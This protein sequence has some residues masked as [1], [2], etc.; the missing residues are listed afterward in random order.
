[1]VMKTHKK[2][3][4]LG[5]ALGY[6][7]GEL[8]DVRFRKYGLGTQCC[9]ANW[10]YSSE[11]GKAMIEKATLKAT[12]PRVELEKATNTSK[13]RKRLPVVLKQT[14]IVFNEFIRLRDKHQP[15]ISSGFPLGSLY[16]A[17][18][19]FSVKQYSGLRFDDRNVHAQ[20]IGDNR[21]KEGNF[22]DYLVQVYLRLDAETV[23]QLRKDAHYFKIHPKKWTIEEVLEIK[24]EYQTKLKALK[25]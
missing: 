15:C 11:E 24:K 2:C 1:M 12:A 4:G 16:D 19:L 10:L 5:K 7:C 3:K 22:E 6:G 17:G 20:S 14:Q 21:H 8:V 25:Q 18:H 13:E 23:D 9:Y